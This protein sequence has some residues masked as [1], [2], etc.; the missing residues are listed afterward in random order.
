[1]AQLASCDYLYTKELYSIYYRKR[2]QSGMRIA[3]A[4]CVAILAPISIACIAA[5]PAIGETAFTA[6]TA[7]VAG[8][9]VLMLWMAV[10]T[11]MRVPDSMFR[12]FC[13]RHGL[14][15]DQLGSNAFREQVDVDI[16]GMTVAYG[17]A[18][19]VDDEM[20]C[21]PKAWWEWEKVVDT[22]DAIIVFGR[23]D[24]LSRGEDAMIPKDSVHGMSPE[25]LVDEISTRIAAANR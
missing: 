10:K 13:K 9:A 16:D 17:P 8:L 4:I 20:H 24:E 19:C 25:A 14:T 3:C 11:P 2:M 15:D 23:G 22:P 18:G 7:F 12:S 5:A 1:M 21:V 6:M